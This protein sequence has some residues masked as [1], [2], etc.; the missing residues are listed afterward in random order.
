MSV[1]LILNLVNDLN[2]SILCEPMASIILFYS[3]SSIHLV[4]NLYEFNILFI[5][6]PKNE[7]FICK[8]KLFFSNTP[9]M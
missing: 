3:M 1:G 8:K 6:N 9:I 2:K 5:T 4:M 7:L